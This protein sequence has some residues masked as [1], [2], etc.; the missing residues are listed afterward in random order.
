M[1]DEKRYW[2]ST[3][4]LALIKNEE[5]RA[6]TCENIV[7]DARAGRCEIWTSTVTLVEVVK[8]R[9]REN[10]IDS[11][12]EEIITKFLR[13]AFIKVIPLD[14]VTA[15][16]ARRLI[17]D[18]PWLLPR[19]AI[20]LATAIHIGSPVLEHYDDGDIGKVGQRVEAEKLP[21]FPEIRHPK[22]IGQLEI[23]EAADAA[24]KGTDG[25]GAGSDPEP[26]PTDGAGQGEQPSR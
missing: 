20:H 11:R 1:A 2:D 8:L 4:F 18:F 17:W 25:A 21:G 13:N 3:V 12:T 23:P 19:D 10:P 7:N 6:E 5:G 9:A 16:K 15:A 22:W 24:A 26:R 14:A